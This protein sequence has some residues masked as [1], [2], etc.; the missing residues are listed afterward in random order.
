MTKGYK[1]P[2]DFLWGGAIAAHQAEGG[3][4]E[5]G[6][7]VS[8]ADTM[9]AGENGVARIEDDQVLDGQVYPNHWGVEF[10]SH[11]KEDIKL[12]AEMG[13][14]AFRTSI[15][16]TRIYPNGDEDVPNE[17][18]L[19]FY[20]DLFAELHKYN[21]EPIVTLSHFEMPLHLVKAYGGFGSRKVVDCFTKFAET[22]FRRY[23]NQVKYWMT[24]NEIN[25]QTSWRD[26]H[27]LLQNSG[28]ILGKGD[29]WEEKMFQAAHLEFVAAAQ[30]VQIGHAI[31]PTLQIGDMIAF[32]P[33]YPLTARPEDVMYC[34]RAMN[35][36]YYFGDVMALGE[37]PAWLKKYWAKK[38]YD[39]GI[40]PADEAIIKAGTADF[41]GFSYYNSAVVKYSDDNP[42]MD[43]DEFK[44]DTK[45][46][47]VPRSDW[48]WQ[49]DPVGLR[50]S[51]NWMTARWHKPM[52]IVENGFGA[53]DK[54]EADGS[55]HDDY[56]IK[57]L[58]D[59]LLQAEKAVAEDG[60]DLLGYCPWSA[61]D[62]V[63][64]STGEMK[65]RYGFIYVDA[66]DQGHGSWKRSRK[67]S[68]NWYKK[69][70]AS[71]GEDL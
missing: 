6:K 41:V 24:F 15:A 13:M 39:I 28:L 17:A 16:W 66:D 33:I 70:I 48:G 31:D 50:Y 47:Y 42:D 11:Y 19:K 22:C 68:F 45:N 57:Y 63:S 9:R 69:V 30:A 23:H 46:P 44:N 14:T 49:I 71:R 51:L 58:A 62:I 27:P 29:N 67:D 1:M 65:K 60:V 7:G 37:Y 4:Q 52:M 35:Y 53:F 36:R 54:V 32:N 10:Y 2:E 21:I 43:F 18:G 25:N 8:I 38:G 59:H 26:P 56:R 12:F 5:G 3:W 40:T 20:D 34:Q 64:A 55:I 61:I